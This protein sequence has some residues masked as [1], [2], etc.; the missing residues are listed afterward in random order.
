MAKAFAPSTIA[1]GGT[2]TLTISLGN[3][4]ATAAT[5]SAILTDTLPSGVTVAGTPNVGGTCA[6]T[7]TAAAG[8]GTV[9]YASGAT[10]PAGGCTITVDVTSGSP[11]TVTN[12][13][14]AGALQTN[15]GNNAS[16]ATA[17]LT[18]SGADLSGI[19]YHDANHNGS[20]EFGESGT[21]ET[22]Y[23]KLVPRSGGSCAGPADDV[24]SVDSGTGAYTLS[25]V[26]PGDYCLILDT[27]NTLADVTPGRPSRWI[28]ME[29]SDGRREVTAVNFDLSGFDFGLY[30][31]SRLSGTVFKDTGAGGGT[32]NNGTK[33]GGESGLGNLLVSLTD[34]SGSTTYDSG[35]TAGDG[36]FEFYAPGSISDGTTLR[37]VERNLGGYVS[38]GGGAGTTGGGYDRATDAVSFSFAAG[39]TDSGLLF[40]DV[41]ATTFLTDGSRSALPGTVL[42][43]PHTFVAGTAGSVS[44]CTSAVAGPAISG[45]SETLFRDTDCN[46]LFGAGDVPLSGSL[47]LVAD[48]KVCIF[49]KEEVPATAPTNAQNAVT[50]T[51][52][53][54]Y[55][56]AAPAIQDVL[57]RS[58][59]TRVGT[60]TSAGLLLHKA[61][62]KATALPGEDLT[63][64]LTYTNNSSG[65]LSSIVVNDM[66]PAYTTFLS[67]G[68]GVLPSNLTAC[69]VD[70][71]PAVGGTGAVRWSFGGSLSSGAS[72]TVNYVVRIIP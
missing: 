45:W 51:A 70:Q 67:A 30:L 43:F 68:C 66:V 54:D 64:T 42:F 40:G 6:G 27:N 58:D 24:A 39:R 55:A 11:G 56:N 33:D 1:S 46:G 38:T 49:V 37:V 62:D 34:N 47:S 14:A 31:G 2:S 69:T 32:A 28:G 15:Q 8:S 23:V 25:G 50:V 29:E 17:N 13:I 18:V 26:P 12:T 57:T 52:T 48:Q 71:E 5:L 9:S 65:Q 63:Y 72:G 4:N 35:L 44:F 7:V 41:P 21:G 10:I 20:R 60:V 59:L 61:V 22:L 36:T 19:V 53:F 3:A 16:A